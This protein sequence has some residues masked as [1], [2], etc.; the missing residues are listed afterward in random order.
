VAAATSF[1]I[2][3][4]FWE[5]H[6]LSLSHPGLTVAE[7]QHAVNGQCAF[8]WQKQDFSFFGFILFLNSF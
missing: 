3:Y 1:I 8:R 6:S 4:L 5:M 2:E 7:V